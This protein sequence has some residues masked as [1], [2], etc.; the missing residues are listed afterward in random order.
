MPDEIFDRYFTCLQLPNLTCGQAL[1]VG[2]GPGIQT[3]LLLSRLPKGWKTLAIEPSLEL[4]TS[5]LARLDKFGNSTSLYNCRFEEL[6]AHAEF[7]VVWMSEV[8]H[9]LGN[10]SG[11]TGHLA[12]IMRTGGRVLIRTSTHTQLRDRHWYR[13]FPTALKLDLA[14]HPTKGSVLRGLTSA[15]FTNISAITIDESRWIPAQYLL[16]M[17]RERAFSTLHFLSQVELDKGLQRLRSSLDSQPETMWHY[18]MTA[19][20]ATF[21]G[22]P[23]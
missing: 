5:A 20:T 13:F 9:L 15:G 11:W 21:Q 6:P 23:L 1:D 17:M 22:G 12:T 8:V 18:V 4:A 2:A 7:D 14:R 10:V 16:D 3:E 19:Y